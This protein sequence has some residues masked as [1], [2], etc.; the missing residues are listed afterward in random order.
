MPSPRKRACIQQ[1]LGNRTMVRNV[2]FLCFFQFACARII[3]KF[4]K[5]SLPFG[6]SMFQCYVLHDFRSLKVVFLY[7]NL[8]LSLNLKKKH[9][10]MNAYLGSRLFT[11]RRCLTVVCQFEGYFMQNLFLLQPFFI[12]FRLHD[13]ALRIA[14]NGYKLYT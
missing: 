7:V 8:H 11:V 3:Y 4:F 1:N 14:Y 5:I 12:C 9:S 6:L 13:I 10:K 2:D